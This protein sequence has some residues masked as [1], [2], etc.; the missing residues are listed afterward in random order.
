MKLRVDAD[1]EIAGLDEAE[2]GQFCYP[3][4]VHPRRD[5]ISASRTSSM[6]PTQEITQS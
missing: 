4:F 5:A 6:P 3:D 1:V 2:F